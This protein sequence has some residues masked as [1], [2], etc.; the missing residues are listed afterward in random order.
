MKDSH[1]ESLCPKG[2]PTSDI[3]LW[4]H[5][6][7]AY[8]HYK[9]CKAVGRFPEDSVVEANAAIIAEVESQWDRMKQDRLENLL[10]QARHPR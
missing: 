8:E 7:A 1:G 6:A 9:R 3:A 5:N 2:S 4:S 10:A